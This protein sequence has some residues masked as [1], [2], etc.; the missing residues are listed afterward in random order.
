MYSDIMFGYTVCDTSFH[1]PIEFGGIIY[2]LTVGIIAS[3]MNKKK[4]N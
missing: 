1:M 2:K 4:S 3:G